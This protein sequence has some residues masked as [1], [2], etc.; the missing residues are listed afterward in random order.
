MSQVRCQGR[1]IR[2]AAFGQETSRTAAALLLALF[3]IPA[4]ALAEDEPAPIEAAP[5]QAEEAAAPVVDPD[6]VVEAD[7]GAETDPP[8]YGGIEE[9]L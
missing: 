5:E 7:P 8:E 6:L 9:I 2:E 3:L 1:V 4:S